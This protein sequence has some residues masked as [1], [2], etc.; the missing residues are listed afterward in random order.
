MTGVVLHLPIPP[1]ANNLFPTGKNGQRF[2]SKEYVAWLQHAGLS[3]N[4]QKPDKVSGRIRVV[5]ELGRY[6]DLRRRDLFNREK[7]LG[8]L[9][10]SHGVIEDDCLIDEGIMRWSDEVRPG[11]VRVKVMELPPRE[12]RK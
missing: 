2:R 11:M 4:Q 9:L 5:Y 1:S 7:A 12:W 10:V 6:P 8:D 3:L